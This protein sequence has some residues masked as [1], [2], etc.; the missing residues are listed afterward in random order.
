MANFLDRVDA[1]AEAKGA[2]VKTLW[3][4]AKFIIVAILTT[5][6]QI[7]LV[8]LLPKLF[9]NWKTPLTGF[10]G[11]IFNEGIIGEGNS[12]WGYILPYFLSLAIANT[13]NYIINKNKTFKS[14]APTWHFVVYFAVLVA[15][16]L[17][18]TWFQGVFVNW[19]TS[20]SIG[21]GEAGARSL[22]SVAAGFIMSLVMFPLQKFVLLREKKND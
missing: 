3:Q 10:L 9:T 6:V 13:I 5:G 8:N 22:G 7:L 14:D 2:V 21:M 15:L 12:T 19:M 11:N 4:L 18:S 16:I 1:K 17:F 20:P